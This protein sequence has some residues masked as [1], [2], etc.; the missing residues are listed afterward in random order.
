MDRGRRLF[1][2]FEYRKNHEISGTQENGMKKIEKNGWK[3]NE[4][5]MRQ[6]GIFCFE[7]LSKSSWDMPS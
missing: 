6:R 5:Y 1:S 7:S 4:A 3:V 2:G